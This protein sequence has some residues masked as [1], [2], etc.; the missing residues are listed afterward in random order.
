MANGGGNG[1]QTTQQTIPLDLIV[2]VVE[3]RYSARQTA[4]AR[5]W[6]TITISAIAV[7][8]TV[9]STIVVILFQN[10]SEDQAKALTRLQEIPVSVPATRLDPE[11]PVPGSGSARSEED[12][13]EQVAPFSDLTPRS[14]SSNQLLRDGTAY[15]TIAVPQGT[16]VINAEGVG[17]FDPFISLYRMQGAELHPIASNDDGGEGQDARLIVELLENT[18]YQ[19]GSPRTTWEPR[20]CRS[21]S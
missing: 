6:A 18:V 16:Y 1:L 4:T 11:S 14:Y 17:G 15:F 7:L 13:A 3:A 12:S 19:S 5:W 8:A 10:A 9:A 20:N 2:E 21:I